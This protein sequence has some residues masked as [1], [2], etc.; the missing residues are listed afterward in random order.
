MIVFSL[1]LHSTLL[2][3]NSFQFCHSFFY[4]H[5]VS[6]L[7][8]ST[9]S[10]RAKNLMFF[11]TQFKPLN[12]IDF[13]IFPLFSLYKKVQTFLGITVN[14]WNCPISNEFIHKLIFCYGTV[15]S[16]GHKTVHYRFVRTFSP[17][18]ILSQIEN[19]GSYFHYLDSKRLKLAQNYEN[20][21]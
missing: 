11:W 18:D 16:N 15:C 7:Y 8:T 12:L 9:K 3:S 5:H 14:L 13:L 10:Q 4:L 19:F 20:L 2:F 6:W 17:Q 1:P 21:D